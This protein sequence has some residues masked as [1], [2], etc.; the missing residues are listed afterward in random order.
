MTPKKTELTAEDFIAAV[1]LLIKRVRVDAPR[2]MREF[3]WTQKSV[4]KYLEK[5]P[6]TS[7]ELARREGVKPQSMGVAIALLEKMEL[8][9][10]KPHPTDGRQ[11]NIKLTAKG[12]AFRKRVKEA[13]ETWISRAL[14]NLDKEERETLFKATEL[15]KRIVEKQ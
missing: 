1:S 14:E 13:T 2:E 7:A 6:A 12:V 9:E 5:G 10:R 15:M 4:L 11:M 8:I 3:T